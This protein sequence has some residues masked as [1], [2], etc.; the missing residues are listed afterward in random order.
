MKK[1]LLL[2]A[3]FMVTACIG[4]GPISTIKPSGENTF[5]QMEGID[6]LGET[7]NVPS[8]FAGNLNIVAVAFERDQQ[9]DVNTWIDVAENIM[10][11]HN[12]IKFYELPVIY[13]VNG[14]Y[15][16]WINNGMRSGI[17]SEEARERTIT[18]YTDREK[19]TSMMDMST[20]EIS[21]LLL[22]GNG[23]MLWRRNGAATEQTISELK[24]AIKDNKK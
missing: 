23:K 13:E 12:D 14:M 21:V 1:F 4:A 15:R 8:T 6:L 16:T 2:G 3:V 18:V 20:D 9:K 11:D 7:R 10:K 22:D 24:T 5:P 17:P 19:F